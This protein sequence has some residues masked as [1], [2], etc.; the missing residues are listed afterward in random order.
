MPLT[1]GTRIGAYA[2]DALLGAGGMGEVYRARDTKLNRDVA[3]KVLPPLVA[4]DPDRLARFRRE[5]QVLAS[6]NDPHIA[7]I[8]GFEDAGGT[9]ALVMELVDGPTLAERIARGPIP[10]DDALAI[11]RQIAAALAAAHEQGIVHRDLKPANVKVREDGAVKVLDFGLA[12]ALGPDSSSAMASGDAANSPTITTPAMTAI[13]M[14]LGTAAYMAPEQARG[15]PVDKRADIWAFGVVL[16]EMLTGRR[17][18]DGDDITETLASVVKEAP[19]LTAVPPSVRRALARCLEKDPR[20]RLRDIG[21]VWDLIDEPAP[22]ASA[23]PPRAWADWRSWALAGA[24]V[25]AAASAVAALWRRPPVSLPRAVEFELLPPE[26]A[27]FGTGPMATV[28]SPDGRA[29][30]F[31]AQTDVT[32]DQD[33]SSSLWVR[34][35][36]SNTAWMSLP[37]TAEASCPFWS[38]DSQSVA[39]VQDGKLRRTAIAG[40]S[41]VTL[42]DVTGQCRGG[43]WGRAGTIVLSDDTKLVRVPAS[44]GTPQPLRAPDTARQER[45]L[46]FPQFLPDGRHFLF[47]TQSEIDGVR[48]TDVSSIDAPAEATRILPGASAKYVAPDG[49]YPGFV[50]WPRGQTLVAQRFDADRLRLDGDPAL[51]VDNVSGVAFGTGLALFSTSDTG[52]LAYHLKGTTSTPRSTLTWL[53]RAGHAVGTVGDHESYGELALS[54]DGSRVAVWRGDS[55]GQ[56]LWFIDVARGAS[57]RLT[58]EAGNQSYPVWSPDGTQIVFASIGNGGLYRKPAGVSGQEAVLL[59]NGDRNLPLDWSRDGRYL[60]YDEGSTRIAD[61]DLWVLPMEANGK[62][63][64]YLAT[65][66]NEINAKFSPDGHWVAYQ[67]NQST[68]FEIYVSPFPDAAAAPAALVSTAGGVLPRWSHDGR[69]L[70]YV[71]ADDELMEVPV[72]PGATFKVGT[73]VPLFK[74]PPLQRANSAGVW[75]WDVTADGQ[76]F[77]VNTTPSQEG[78]APAPIIVDTDWRAKL[79]R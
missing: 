38:P 59:E 29:I 25:V 27:R 33:R 40:G 50:L 13:G 23:Q 44:G 3:L 22:A 61:W 4:N 16:Y 32:D 2:I 21:D 73:P 1:Q 56:N 77:L 28:V 14:I 66:F 53:D 65:P 64:P 17:P 76:R 70:Y 43:T 49:P 51:V 6:L 41:P 30:V 42:A 18:F 60:L 5:A 37:G 10:L 67:S 39:F 74:L 78:A 11:A 62:P 54:P 75:T 15:R 46:E 58:T 31:R 55:A 24:I 79:P 72:T 48:G 7:Q 68:R 69:A 26:G 36:D 12:K 63:R 35:L 9:H 57:A 47:Y 8:Y 19:D 20:K 52:V 71:S 34:R 45:Y